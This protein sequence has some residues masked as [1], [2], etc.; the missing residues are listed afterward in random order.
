MGEGWSAGRHPLTPC[1][2][3]ALLSFLNVEGFHSIFQTSVLLIQ[4]SAR[5]PH[6][7][8]QALLKASAYHWEAQAE[9]WE[10]GPQGRKEELS[11]K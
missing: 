7:G 6:D 4:P 9:C 3:K 10:E 8:Q 5:G 11:D 2:F 1:L